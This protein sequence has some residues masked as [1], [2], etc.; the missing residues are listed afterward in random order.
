M[1]LIWANMKQEITNFS[2]LLLL[3]V[4]VNGCK[5]PDWGYSKPYNF[6]SQKVRKHNYVDGSFRR[7]YDQAKAANDEAS[8]RRE[9]NQILSELMYIIDADHGDYERSTQ[10][11]ATAFEVLSDFTVLG[12]TGAGAVTGGAETKSILSAIASGVMG[13]QLSV[14]KRVFRDKTIEAL[15]AQMRAAQTQRKAEIISRMK[16]TTDDYTLELGLSGIVQYYYDGTMTRALQNMV[17]DAKEKEKQAEIS[18]S[19]NL[20]MLDKASKVEIT[21]VEGLTDQ[22][23]ALVKNPDQAAARAEAQR[24]LKALD[25]T[26]DPKETNDQL[27]Q[28]LQDQI[29]TATTNHTLLPKLSGAFA[30]P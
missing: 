24:I 29:N 28:K 2:L 18:V 26:V 10:A 22:L 23:G 3:I 20:L 8:A 21:T 7:D 19:T 11:H 4:T 6:A 16:Q 1:K 14:N 17:A 13:A 25:M 15:Q 12:L 30:K 5:S 27:Y 9:R